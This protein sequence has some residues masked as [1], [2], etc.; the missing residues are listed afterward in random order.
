MT[1]Q[2]LISVLMPAWNAAPWIADAIRSVLDQSWTNWELLIVDDGSSDATFDVAS[3]FSDERI[4]LIRQENQGAS[5]A[6]NRAFRACRGSH[7]QYLDADD[8]LDPEK[9]SAQMAIARSAPRTE[10]LSGR[11]ARFIDNP[12]RQHE[13]PDALWRDLSPRGFLCQSLRHNLMMHP[14]AWLSPRELLIQ[15]GP[16]NE[17]ISV[18][19][20]GEYFA[21]VIG[22]ST[23]IRFVPTSLSLYRS[24]VPAS[25]STRTGIR[26]A[27]SQALALNEIAATLRRLGAAEAGEKAIAVATARLGLGLLPDQSA[28]ANALLDKVD[29]DSFHIACLER[30]GTFQWMRRLLGWRLGRMAEERLSA[31]RRMARP[32]PAHWRGKLEDGR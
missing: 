5:A 17:G 23:G 27:E 28:V 24:V 7:V 13:S 10:L 15:A 11:W 18:N 32:L 21:R 6:R 8:L 4:T 12:T 16:W 9:L 2:S 3:Q 29:P 1:D 25:L 19:D 14:A 31:I 26:S 30:P 20:D 22:A